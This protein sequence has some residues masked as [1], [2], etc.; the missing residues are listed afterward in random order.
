MR[1][2]YLFNQTFPLFKLDK[3]GKE[4]FKRGEY[5]GAEIS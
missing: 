1:E 3:E 4:N 5:K 2:K